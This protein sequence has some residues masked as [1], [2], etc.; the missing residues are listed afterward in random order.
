MAWHYLAR[1]SK[2]VYAKVHADSISKADTHTHKH[3]PAIWRTS[4]SRKRVC[5]SARIC[6]AA[7]ASAA[8]GC[9]KRSLRLQCCLRLRHL[10]IVPEPDECSL[11]LLKEQIR[12]RAATCSSLGQGSTGGAGALLLLLRSSAAACLKRHLSPCQH[13][14]AAP[15]RKYLHTSCC[16]GAGLLLPTAMLLVSDTH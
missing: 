13:D 15:F 11:R 2:K 14:A 3:T 8:A 4:S 5:A 6:A 7:G 10:G 12:V 9:N 16:A 1:V